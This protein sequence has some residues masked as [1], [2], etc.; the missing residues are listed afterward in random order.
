[1]I[2]WL[3]TPDW[4]FA[5]DRD[6]VEAN[7]PDSFENGQQFKPGE[8]LWGQNDA[9]GDG[10]MTTGPMPFTDMGDPVPMDVHN[11]NFLL[12]PETTAAQYTVTGTAFADLNGNGTFDGNDAPLPNATVYWDTNRDG[13]YENGEPTVLT[14][15]GTT[16][17]LGKYTITLPAN[18][19]P[20]TYSFGV[21]LPT[22]DW[23]FK[24]PIT[25]AEEVFLPSDP[26]QTINFALMR[27]PMP[28]HRTR[29]RAPEP[30]SW[31]SYSLISIG[32]A[33]ARR[34]NRERPASRSSSILSRTKC[35]T[36]ENPL[37]SPRATVRLCSTTSR[38]AT[39]FGSMW[40]SATRERPTR[41]TA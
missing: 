38:P 15:D 4:F 19:P 18:T 20:G 37:R 36:A 5:P 14:G 41:F 32:M 2:E 12:K 22:S 34:T 8:I 33:F 23:Q 26:P 16:G 17:P 9:N 25:G 7:S 13:A 3:I 40:R 21:R 28:F 24:A 30:R 10:V 29:R 11:I 1:M 27:Q 31:A 39:T 35:W 6:N